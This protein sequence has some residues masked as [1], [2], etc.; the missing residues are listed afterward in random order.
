MLFRTCIYEFNCIAKKKYHNMIPKFHRILLR[1]PRK[2]AMFLPL[3]NKR[4]ERSRCDAHTSDIVAFRV[5]PNPLAKQATGKLGHLRA[6]IEMWR[7]R[8]LVENRVSVRIW[9]P[10][11]GDVHESLHH[12]VQVAA[13]ANVLQTH[14][15]RTPNFGLLFASLKDCDGKY[16]NM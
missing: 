15:S 8:T 6:E 2:R 7:C 4:L 3:A 9:I 5:L 10:D 14:A 16:F 11:L 1:T 12:G 13:V